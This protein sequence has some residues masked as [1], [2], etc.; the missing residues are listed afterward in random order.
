MERRDGA[1]DLRWFT[2]AAEVDLCG[3]ATLATAHVLGGTA[4]FRT[5]SGELHCRLGA[6][7][8]VEMDFPADPLTPDDLAVELPGADI[9]AVARGRSDLMVAVA[10]PDWVRGYRPDTTA[11]SSLDA[12]GLIVTARGDR[13]GI[14]FVSRFF[15]PRV[16]VA[17][18]PVT[19]SAH[20]TLAGY[21]A[22]RT[23]RPEMTGYQASERGG[24][25]RVRVEGDRVV[26]M[27][28]AVT[29]SEVRMM[30]D[31]PD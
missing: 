25:V 6:S 2:P 11:I 4:R 5:R 29:V 13:P 28:R 22:S 8:L 3:H 24:T 17:E 30:V 23:G 20:C 21:W 9:E 14:D 19:G 31:R 12:R 18:D 15:A 10:D 1:Y 16:G 26:L 7:G 27:G